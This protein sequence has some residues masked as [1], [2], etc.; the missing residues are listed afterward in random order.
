MTCLCAEDAIEDAVTHLAGQDLQFFLFCLIHFEN[1]LLKWMMVSCRGLLI[2]GKYSKDSLVC[3]L[4][5]KKNPGSIKIV[6]GFGCC[7]KN[8][9]G[10]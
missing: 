9:F 6:P 8:F 7:R 2:Q 5:K 4:G 1:Y 10:E 3:L